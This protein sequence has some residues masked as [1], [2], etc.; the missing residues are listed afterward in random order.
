MKPTH[1]LKLVEKNNFELARQLE[2]CNLGQIC[3]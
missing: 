3:D 1:R 2:K